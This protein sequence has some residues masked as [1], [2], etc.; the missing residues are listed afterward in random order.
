M[1]YIYLISRMPPMQ[2]IDMSLAKI[3]HKKVP[4]KLVIEKLFNITHKPQLVRTTNK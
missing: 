4:P 3:E 1:D 2:L